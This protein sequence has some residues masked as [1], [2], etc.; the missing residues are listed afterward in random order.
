MYEAERKEIIDAARMLDRYGL[1]ALSGG[2]VSLRVKGDAILVTPSGMFYDTMVPE[3]I[4]LVDLEGNIKAGTRKASVDTVA[5]LYIYNRMPSVHAIIHTHQPYATAL[6]LVMDRIPCNLTT[7]ANGT[8]GAVAVA[9]YTSAASLEMGVAAVQYLD[10][11]LA[12]VLKNHGVIAVGDTLRQALYSCVYL[13]EAAK[14]QAIA[15]S[16]EKDIPELADDQVARAV[17]V[18]TTYG[19]KK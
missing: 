12:V 1:I 3:D 7:L 16:I 15:Y 2:N 5:L 8:R 19:Q 6:G 9:P 11:K 4:L 13:E 10:D 17:E 18:F 14:T